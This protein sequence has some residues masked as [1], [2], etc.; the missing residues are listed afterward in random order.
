MQKARTFIEEHKKI[1][2]SVGAGLLLLTGAGAVYGVEE[3]QESQTPERLEQRRIETAKKEI[4]DTVAIAS[5]QVTLPKDEEAMLA[6][7]SDR[8]QL[9]HQKFFQKAQNG[10]Q[11]LMYPKNKK[12][13]LYRPSTKKVIAFSTLSFDPTPTPLPVDESKEVAG[14]SSVSGKIL[15]EPR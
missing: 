14:E 15:I 7:V 6:S 13:F 10:D 3:Y 9:M 8:E 4:K 12:I 5:D 11:L 2:M 1:S